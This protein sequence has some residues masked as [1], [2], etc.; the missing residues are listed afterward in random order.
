MKIRLFASFLILAT[1]IGSPALAL[2]CSKASTA[3][4]HKICADK[5]LQK[6]DTAMGTAYL[7]LLH[8]AA[9]PDIRAAL[10]HSQRRWIA[11]RESDLGRLENGDDGLDAIDQRKI[12]LDATVART[13]YL[14]AQ[15]DGKPQFITDALKQRSS[16]AGYSDGPFGGYSSRCSFIPDQQDHSIYTYDCF[17]ALSVQ[18]G[19]RVCTDNQDFASYT[20]EE[21][22]A[23][24]DIIDGKLK[25]IATCAMGTSNDNECPEMEGAGKK[26]SWNL[27]PSPQQ[28]GIGNATPLTKLDP[29]LAVSTGSDQDWLKTCLTDKSFPLSNP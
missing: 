11:A 7:H 15:V 28:A 10:I 29:E 1:L 6:A 26:A 17:G 5:G 19:D 9:D 21:Q 27:K 22:R 8:L 20:M 18:N 12:L 23:V 25:V 16:V 2:D 24:A 4:E 13:K 14:T 3:L